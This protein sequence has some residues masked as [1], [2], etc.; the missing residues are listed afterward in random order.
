MFVFKSYIYIYIYVYMSEAPPW[1]GPR[2]G[3]SSRGGKI[4]EIPHDFQQFNFVDDPRQQ[5]R[6]SPPSVVWS[7]SRIESQ[8]SGRRMVKN[9]R[10]FK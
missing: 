6:P 10:E 9:H 7:E 5:G 3:R 8:G 2:P 4:F 1:Y